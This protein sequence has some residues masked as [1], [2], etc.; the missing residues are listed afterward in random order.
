M[1]YDE[2]RAFLGLPRVDLVAGGRAAVYPR[3]SGKDSGSVRETFGRPDWKAHVPPPVP[4]ARPSR[5]PRADLDKEIVIAADGLSIGGR[6]FPGVIAKDSLHV[7]PICDAPGLWRVDLSLLTTTP[8]RFIGTRL[9]EADGCEVKL[10]SG[11]WECVLDHRYHRDA[12]LIDRLNGFK[13]G[14]T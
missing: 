14:R 12:D 9:V 13:I 4:K 3:Q 2:Q 1:S 8:P 6:R 5:D 10:R 7:E 11:R